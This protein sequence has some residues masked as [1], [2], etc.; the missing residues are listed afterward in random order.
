MPSAST[1]KQERL[2]SSAAGMTKKSLDGLGTRALENI[3][4]LGSLEK[5]G[6]RRGQ[7]RRVTNDVLAIL[8][9]RKKAK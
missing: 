7:G 2:A 6:S 8:K 5:F 3:K 1:K 4:A 9:Q